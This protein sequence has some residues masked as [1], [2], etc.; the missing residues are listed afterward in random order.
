[1]QYPLD[2]LKRAYEAADAAF[3]TEGRAAAMAE[4]FRRICGT[5]SLEM[6]E[7]GAFFAR[8]PKIFL[9][10]AISF[11]VRKQP[12]EALYYLGLLDEGVLAKP[13]WFPMYGYYKAWGYDLLGDSARAKAYLVHHLAQFKG[14]E[15]ARQNLLALGAGAPRRW[16]DASLLTS[17]TGS[18][19]DIPIFINSRDRLGTLQDLILRLLELGQRTVVVL[20]NGSTYAPLLRYYREIEKH[21]IRVVRLPNLGHRA[22]WDS[23]VLRTLGVTGAYAYTD[24]DIALGEGFPKDFMRRL[25]LC[26]SKHPYL[27]K[28]GL[29]LEYRDITFYDREKIQAIES[30]LYEIPLAKDAY[31]A[32]VD[33]TFAV[34]RG[35]IRH[36]V[37]GPSARLAGAL[38]ARHLPWYYDE[39]NRPADETYYMEHAEAY[40]SMKGF[41]QLGQEGKQAWQRMQTTSGTACRA[42][43]KGTGR[44][45]QW[46]FADPSSGTER[47]ETGTDVDSKQKQIL[48]KVIGQGRFGLAELLF[49]SCGISDDEAAYRVFDTRQREEASAVLAAFYQDL[50]KRMDGSNLSLLLRRIEMLSR[51]LADNFQEE[52][53]GETDGVT[54]A[55]CDEIQR[56]ERLAFVLAWRYGWG[57]L[58]HESA[59]FPDDERKLIAAMRA[60]SLASVK[61]IQEPPLVSVMIPAYNLPRLFART[62]RSA[63]IQDW[64]NLEILVADNSTN[65]ETAAEMERYADD[66]R[67]RY[68]RNRTAKTKAENF[69]VFEHEAH[70]EYFQWLMQ[71][72]ILLPQKITCMAR[73]LMDNPQITLVGSQRA[74]IDARGMKIDEAYAAGIR[75]DLGIAGAYARFDGHAVGRAMLTRLQNI[76]GE[77]PAVLFR[78]LDL[79]HHYWRAEARGY[80][81]L[82]DV[83]MWLELLEKGDLLMFRDALSCYRRHGQQEGQ[84]ADILVESRLEWFRLMEEQHTQQAFLQDGDRQTICRRFLA[85]CEGGMAAVSRTVGGALA[86]SY[87]RRIA[88]A[89]A[90][91]SAR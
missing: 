84:H 57:L 16:L 44:H 63:A 85:D 41:Q 81:V 90:F 79:T 66:P 34:Y 23:G 49:Q 59:L 6:S 39:T 15:M 8:K 1:M 82:S 88:E 12:K 26:L 36:Y 50:E 18:Y 69:A 38:T 45:R 27:V 20:D 19:A 17:V 25:L 78:R 64:P 67:V 35:S 9:L 75:P 72:D 51:L 70:G 71:D 7:A 28:A 54:A 14:D 87:E 31:F 43:G 68:I 30:K 86:V 11:L 80:R 10:A 21:G 37:R 91:L 46:A 42:A 4:A 13:A 65:E 73:V 32:D 40:S 58:S 22:L 53:C 76:I 3:D 89:K 83:V 24:S 47:E 55:L 52:I 48:K 61:A 33:T 77:P 56:T 5:P 29:A 62:M 60:A 74:F 2:G